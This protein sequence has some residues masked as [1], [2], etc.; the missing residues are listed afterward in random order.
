MFYV[1]IICKKLANT[2]LNVSY[3]MLLIVSLFYVN[4]IVLSSFSSGQLLRCI[5]T[6]A[7]GKI[8]VEQY[9]L[10][11][12]SRTISVECLHCSMAPLSLPRVPRECRWSDGST[13]VSGR[14]QIWCVHRNVIR[15]N[16]SFLQ[17]HLWEDAKFFFHPRVMKKYLRGFI[18]TR[19]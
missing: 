8:I 17:C 5:V 10:N 3:L 9:S 18:L 13:A 11:D 7:A 16:V 19:F 15:K 1:Y 2:I 14:L 12:I 4:V 6:G